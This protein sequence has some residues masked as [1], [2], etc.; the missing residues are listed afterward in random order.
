MDGCI[1]KSETQ[2]GLLRSRCRF[3]SY[4][5]FYVGAVEIDEIAHREHLSEKRGE[6]RAG[7][8]QI[9]NEEGELMKGLR[10]PREV[11]VFACVQP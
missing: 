8:R 1:C 5:C 2:K 11:G 10:S 7:P 6:Q 9:D 4:P 3:G